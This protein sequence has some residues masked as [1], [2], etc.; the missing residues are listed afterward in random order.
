MGGTV[1]HEPDAEY[2]VNESAVEQEVVF[3]MWEECT[4]VKCKEDGCPGWGW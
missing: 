2:V 3:S 4:L 1:I